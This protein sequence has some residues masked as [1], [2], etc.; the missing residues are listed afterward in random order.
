MGVATRADLFEH[1]PEVFA[2]LIRSR[3]RLRS[4]S[5]GRL[6]G[7]RILLLPLRFPELVQAPP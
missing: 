6:A 4:G 5:S 1:K 2:R 3:S 7:S